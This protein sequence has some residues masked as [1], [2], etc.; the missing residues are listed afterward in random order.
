MRKRN[1]ILLAL[2][3]IG[4]GAYIYF[5]ERHLPTTEERRQQADTLF[6]D[7]DRD[8]VAG[9]EI[10]N[11]HGDFRLVKQGGSWRL[12]APIE[13][14]AEETAVSS[15]LGSLENLKAERTLSEGEVDPKAY[16]L[17]RPSITLTLATD[18]GATSSLEIGDEAALGSNRAVRRNGEG[19]V[20]LVSG[21]F[22]RDLDRDLDEWRS[23]DVAEIAADDVASLVVLAG[24]DRIELVRQGESWRLLQPL[25]DVAD[26]DHVR[27]LIS[28]LDALR[29]EEFLDDPPPAAELGLEVPA[30]QVT[31]LRSS[32]GEPLRLDFGSSRERDGRTQVA[33]RRN[34]AEL[35]WV[36][37]R[38]ATRLAKAP[39]RWRS[40][41]VAAFDTWD[42]ERLTIT[43]GGTGVTLARKEGMWTAGE[44]GGEVEHSE[45]QDRLAA[46]AALE[47]IEFDLV[48]PA[49]PPAGTVE[50]ELKPPGGSA[51]PQLLSFSFHRPLVEGGQALVRV[52]GRATV[53]SVAAAQVEQ[54]LADP[55][56]LVRPAEDPAPPPASP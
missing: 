2:M 10:H 44:G 48:E 4:L 25:D 36:D 9:L 3:V 53:M 35:F 31:I 14:A 8:E 18:D 33:C 52:S 39:V 5:H 46:L 40:T 51:E 26:R 42:A 47:A 22:V 34:A 55:R 21:W 17:D 24:S 6:P 50:L 43:A 49:T 11:T 32:G 1:L 28:D 15:L 20:I 27:N 16:G 13:F 38:A 56:A 23:R 29:V 54:I 45:V 7:L 19:S 30:Y 12:V 41:K 37:D